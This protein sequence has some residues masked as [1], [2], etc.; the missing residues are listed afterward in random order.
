MDPL[1]LV[2][3]VTAAAFGALLTVMVVGGSPML[4]LP[5]AVLV[6]AVGHVVTRPEPGDHGDTDH[7]VGGA[8]FGGG[9]VGDR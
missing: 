3:I 6:G 2:A 4:V 8:S 9:R 5:V 7:G 1:E